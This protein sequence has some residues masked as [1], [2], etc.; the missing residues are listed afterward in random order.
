MERGAGGLVLF[1]EDELAGFVAV[2]LNDARLVFGLPLNVAEMGHLLA[3]QALAVDEE[4]DLVEVGVGPDGY[5]SP[6]L[7]SKFQWGKRCSDGF[8]PH[9]AL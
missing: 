1:S 6:S 5:V 4:L 8:L 3:A 7:P 9:Q 2:R